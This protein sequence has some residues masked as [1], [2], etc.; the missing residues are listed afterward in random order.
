M[1]VSKSVLLASLPP[2]MGSKQLIEKQQGVRD[3]INEILNAHDLYAS[4]YDKIAVF[5]DGDNVEKIAKDLWTFVKK[6]VKYVI[7]SEEK[8]TTKSP[9]AILTTGKGDCKHYSSFVGGVLDALKRKGKKINWTYRFSGYKLFDKT[10]QHVFVVIKKPNGS[11]VWVDAVLSAFDERKSYTVAV[12]KKPKNMSLYRVSGVDD[13]IIG[14]AKKD[15]SAKKAAKKAKRAQRKKEGKGILRKVGK[16]IK[17]VAKGVVKF[18]AVPARNAYLLLVKFNIHGFATA[19]QKADQAKVKAKWEKL[20]GKFSALQKAYTQGAKKKKIFGISGIS[21][22]EMEAIGAAPVGVAAALAAAVPIIAALAPL[23]KSFL[24]QKGK[25]AVDNAINDVSAVV[26]ATQQNLEA[27]VS[28]VAKAQGATEAETSALMTQAEK[29]DEASNDSGSSKSIIPGVSNTTL[30]LG[31][32]AAAVAVFA[33][34]KSK[35]R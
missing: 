22:E 29:I 34:S 14:K 10:P 8:Q 19:L 7:E 16:G 12:D 32:G 20:G 15:K 24:D 17:A 11:E 25:Q 18:A 23:L 26:D 28:D 1:A 4:Q 5:F 9:S 33:F 35:R 30:F 2:Y 6:N 21:M 27:A 13:M 3:I 31:A